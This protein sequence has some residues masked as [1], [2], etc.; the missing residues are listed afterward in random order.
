M[1]CDE[2]IFV[3]SISRSNSVEIFFFSTG[4][5]MSGYENEV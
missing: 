2:S 1:D 4:E 5:N 3:V